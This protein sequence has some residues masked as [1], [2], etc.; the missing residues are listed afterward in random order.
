MILGSLVIW[1][2]DNVDWLNGANYENSGITEKVLLTC[3]SISVGKY[4]IKNLFGKD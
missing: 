4:F 3:L 2:G 1:F